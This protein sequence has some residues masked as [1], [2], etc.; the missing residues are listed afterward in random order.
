M[1]TAI[2]ATI[3]LDNFYTEEHRGV[4]NMEKSHIKALNDAAFSLPCR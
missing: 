1:K 4:V 3:F 2:S